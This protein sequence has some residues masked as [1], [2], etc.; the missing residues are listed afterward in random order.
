MQNS[1]YQQGTWTPTDASG[2]G[3]VFTVTNAT[4]TRVGR[5]V[6]VLGDITYPITANGSTALIGGLPF[7]VAN[8]TP[9]ATLTDVGSSVT[10]LGNVASVTAYVLDT[11]T[12]AAKT[13]ASLSGKQIRFSLTYF[14]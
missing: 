7:T 4:Y 14:I 8:N 13:N 2:Q 10:V 12:T 5:S 3:L 9:G 1:D 6:T 11:V